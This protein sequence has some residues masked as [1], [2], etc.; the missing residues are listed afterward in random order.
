MGFF[1]CVNPHEAEVIFSTVVVD[2]HQLFAY[3]TPKFEGSAK[4]K[5]LILTLMTNGDLHFNITLI[6]NITQF[7]TKLPDLMLEGGNWFFSL[8]LIMGR[9]EN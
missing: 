4:L 7:M 9:S 6:Y 1:P 8:C 3:H 5:R 2:F